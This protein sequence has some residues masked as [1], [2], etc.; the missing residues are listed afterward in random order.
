MPKP[1]NNATIKVIPPFKKQGEFSCLLALDENMISSKVDL[2]K[3]KMKA[4]DLLE[5]EIDSDFKIRVFVS[6]V[7][8]I[9]EF[10][11]LYEELEASYAIF[12]PILKMLKSDFIKRYPKNLRPKVKELIGELEA[13][14]SKKL[15]H[16]VR[17]KKK[18]KTL[19]LY[20][21]RI[22]RVYVLQKLIIFSRCLLT[23]K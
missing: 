19:R 10:R 16:I 20:E 8:L 2:D 23:G 22:E 1:L 14:K 6:T 7:N 5:E 17:E 11:K 13:M 15:E 9:S 18:P 3:C 4:S 21:P 12:E